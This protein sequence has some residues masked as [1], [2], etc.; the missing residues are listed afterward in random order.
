MSWQSQVIALLEASLVRPFVLVAAAWLLVW[1]FRIRHPASRHAVWTAVLIG[2]LLLPFASVTMPQWKLPVLPRKHESAAQILPVAAG[3]AGVD[4]GIARF[5]SDGQLDQ[6][7]Q[8]DGKLLVDFFGAF[9]AATD[10]AIQ[11]NG[12]IIAAGS[13]EPMPGSAG[14]LFWAHAYSA[15]RTRSGCASLSRISPSTNS[16]CRPKRVT[17]RSLWRTPCSS[18]SATNWNG[19]SS[20][21]FLRERSYRSGWDRVD[22]LDGPPGSRRTGL[23]RKNIAAMPAFSSAND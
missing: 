19:R 17:C 6:T 23:Q 11:P 13:A 12:K 3:P 7:F 4:F 14:K 1:A 10:V 22:D 16:S 2:M 8:D 21:P 18:I 9:D 5:T 20:S 15:S